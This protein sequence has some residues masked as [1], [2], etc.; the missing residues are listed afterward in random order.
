[1]EAFIKEQALA[2]EKITKLFSN[3]KKDGPSRRTKPYLESRLERLDFEWSEF[4]SRD[5]KLQAY[6]TEKPESSYFERKYYEQVEAVYTEYK[7]AI[8][9][10]QADHENA[11][12]ISAK[13]ESGN[14]IQK[15]IRQQKASIIAMEHILTPTDDDIKNRSAAYYKQ[16]LAKSL[17]Y[18]SKSWQKKRP[19][20][21]RL[22]ASRTSRN[23]VNHD[24]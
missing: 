22:K 10:A 21:I 23:A 1:M 18:I 16:K 4:E 2:A 5:I 6:R 11:G 19:Q 9:Q 15:L 14:T 24:S 8:L 17:D 20:I 7:A 3:F 12:N 13:T